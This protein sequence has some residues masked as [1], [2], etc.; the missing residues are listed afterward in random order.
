MVTTGDVLGVISDPFGEV[1]TE[2]LAG[3]DG[4]LIGRTHLPIVNEGDGLF[5]IARI[6]SSIDAETRIDALTA[7]LQ[8]DVLLDEDEII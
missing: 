4:L 2:V 7:Q 8:E 3:Y 1:E 5:H 6:K